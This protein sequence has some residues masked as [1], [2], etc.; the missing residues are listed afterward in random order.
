MQDR[1]VP[2]HS[3]GR[4]RESEF[5]AALSGQGRLGGL[6]SLTHRSIRST[7]VVSMLFDP[8]LPVRVPAGPATYPPTEHRI[9]TPPFFALGSV[10]FGPSRLGVR[11]LMRFTPEL[12][13]ATIPSPTFR[14]IALPTTSAC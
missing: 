8:R 13:V 9:P 10:W 3:T 1:F 6:R 7:H 11:S 12:W 2:A 5:R 14:E 4:S